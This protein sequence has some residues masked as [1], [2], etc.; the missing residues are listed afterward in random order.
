[1]A[2]KKREH[3]RDEYGEYDVVYPPEDKRLGTYR[4][5]W[6]G[7]AAIATRLLMLIRPLLEFGEQPLRSDI[8][9]Y[10]ASQRSITERALC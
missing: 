5:V 1:M 3:G 2:K 9:R 7:G 4:S 8:A 6:H 10:D